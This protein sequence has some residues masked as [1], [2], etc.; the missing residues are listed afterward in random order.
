MIVR[1]LTIECLEA[2]GSTKTITV[3]VAPTPLEVL[4]KHVA[5]FVKGAAA[6]E[7]ELT[8]AVVE[9][10][11]AGARRAKQGITLDWLRLN[12]DAHN[13]DAVLKVF[14]DVNGLTPKDGAAAQEQPSGEANAA[15]AS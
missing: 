8:K 12:V 2:D 15:G 7:G 13:K 11:Y 9:C 6:D 5:T 14:F 3:K 10:V 4:A 1:E